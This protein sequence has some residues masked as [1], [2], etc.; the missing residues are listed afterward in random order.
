MLQNIK[1]LDPHKKV[2]SS[3]INI[4]TFVIYCSNV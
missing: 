4:Y 2:S 3:Y 1:I